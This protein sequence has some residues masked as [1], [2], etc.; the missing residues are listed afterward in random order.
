MADEIARYRRND[1][2]YFFA[3][4]DAILRGSRGLFRVE[5]AGEDLVHVLQLAL[6]VEGVFDLLARHSARDLFVG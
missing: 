4:F 5:D 1:G 3:F 6:Q 2:R